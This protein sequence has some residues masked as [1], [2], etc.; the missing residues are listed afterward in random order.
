M[1]VKVAIPPLDGEGGREAAGW[2]VAVRMA[3]CLW[4]RSPER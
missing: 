4:G 3:D 1:G 2:G